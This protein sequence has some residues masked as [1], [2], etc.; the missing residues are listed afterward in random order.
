M[1]TSVSELQKQ[2]NDPSLIGGLE[3][4]L[5]RENF[6]RGVQRESLQLRSAVCGLATAALQLYLNEVEGVRTERLITEPA[7]A[8]RGVNSRILT[9][10]VLRH[11]G[12]IIDPT[13]SQFLSFIGLDPRCEN[14]DTLYPNV[15]VAVYHEQQWRSIANELTQYA[16]RLD[17]NGSVPQPTVPALAP[18][19]VLRNKPIKQME[20]AYQAITNP[21][22]YRP[23]PLTSQRNFFQDAAASVA[24]SI[25]RR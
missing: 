17:K 12:V 16:F 25:P 2:L 13:Y 20:Q 3:R 7:A 4:G 5:K 18:M 9:H 11:E 8:P 21:T 23:F 15:K 19:G 24:G 14:N 1:Y 10:V 6:A 22:G